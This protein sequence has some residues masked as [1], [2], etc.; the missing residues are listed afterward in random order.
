MGE[1]IVF[2]MSCIVIFCSMI[3]ACGVVVLFS[4]IV[5]DLWLVHRKSDTYKKME[6]IKNTKRLAAWLLALVAVIIL[7]ILIFTTI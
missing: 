4:L 7:D 1:N 5:R 3:P 6:I 2:L